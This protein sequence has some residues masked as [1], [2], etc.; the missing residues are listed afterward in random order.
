MSLPQP[1]NRDLEEALDAIAYLLA[2]SAYSSQVNW[3]L[4]DVGMGSPQ[5]L[6][7]G[8]IS[9]LNES[10]KWYSAAGGLG[11]MTGGAAGVD[12]WIMPIVITIAYQQHRYV[13]PIPA[14][15]SAGS[16]FSGLGTL[17]YMEQP[18]WRE[19]QF[20]IQKVKAVLRTNITVGGFVA[21]TQIVES[22]PVLMNINEILFR[23]VR[24]TIQTQQRRRR[25]T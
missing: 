7:Y 13:D 9:H 5:Q 3:I 17:P 19:A 22:K 15:P 11:G 16:A 24:I 20:Y 2:T 12:D 8:Y 18:G 6:P 14:A 21:T 10:V 25:G 1:V 23:C 4:G